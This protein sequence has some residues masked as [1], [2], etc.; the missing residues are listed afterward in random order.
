MRA[1]FSLRVHLLGFAGMLV[2]SVVVPLWLAWTVW[3]VVV[4]GSAVMA[5]DG[6]H[7]LWC[8]ACGMRVETTYSVCH[9]CGYDAH[10]RRVVGLPIEW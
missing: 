1:L 8:P 4:L 10:V 7:P 2:V 9:Y 6:E 5:Y 3:P